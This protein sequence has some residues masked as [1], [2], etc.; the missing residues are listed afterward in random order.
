MSGWKKA[1]VSIVRMP[2]NALNEHQTK[3]SA[4]QGAERREGAKVQ[5]FLACVDT[6]KGNQSFNQNISCVEDCAALS[7]IY[8]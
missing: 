7:P 4:R 5:I 2:R 3:A 6:I 8:R 1:L